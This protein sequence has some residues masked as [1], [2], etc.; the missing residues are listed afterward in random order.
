MG[1]WTRVWELRDW[2]L[3]PTSAKAALTA[4]IHNTLRFHSVMILELS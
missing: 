4:N 3:I 1:R 2:V